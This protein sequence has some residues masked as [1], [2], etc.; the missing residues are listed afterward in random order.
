MSFGTE[1]GHILRF[2]DGEDRF[3]VWKTLEAANMHQGMAHHFGYGLW[4]GC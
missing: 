2:A 3:Q 4:G 1:M